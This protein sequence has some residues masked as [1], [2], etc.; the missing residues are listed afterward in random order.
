MSDVEPYIGL[1]PNCRP[2]FLEALKYHIFPDRRSKIP[3]NRTTPRKMISSSNKIL[4][5]DIQKDVS[6]D[7]K[8]D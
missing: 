8:L 4:I 7:Y 3:H 6:N 5:V 2:Y 1:I